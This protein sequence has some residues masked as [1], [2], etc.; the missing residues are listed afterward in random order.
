MNEAD[1]EVFRVRWRLALLERL[2]LKTA[3]LADH[4][5]GSLTVAGT[6]TALKGWLDTNSA[7]A[8]RAYGAALEDPALT[9]LF[10]DEVKAITD[11]LKKTV[12]SIAVEAK[13]AFG[14]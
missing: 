9:A 7:T 14:P 6:A 12:D 11:D 2:V 8:D 3:F 5:K 1:L 10:A 4:V 13:K